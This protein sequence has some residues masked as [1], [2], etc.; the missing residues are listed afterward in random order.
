M[1][2]RAQSRRCVVRWRRVTRNSV[3]WDQ[4]RSL[5]RDVRLRRRRRTAINGGGKRWRRFPGTGTRADTSRA[6]K[7]EHRAHLFGGRVM[8]LGPSCLRATA[9]RSSDGD[10]DSSHSSGRHQDRAGKEKQ[11]ETE[12][13]LPQKGFEELAAEASSVVG[14]M[15]GRGAQPWL[16]WHARCKERRVRTAGARWRA[17]AGY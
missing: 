14:A 2:G 7:G 10:G 17:V 6:G 3:A 13:L 8:S 12:A 16:V 5:R 11:A 4:D 9:C 1:L 15:G